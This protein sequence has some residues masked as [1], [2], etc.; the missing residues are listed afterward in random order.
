MHLEFEALRRALP[1]TV[2]PLRRCS[3]SALV[4]QAGDFV[5][6]MPLA[7]PARGQC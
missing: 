7:D 5:E 3:E 4:P 1:Y 2:S 6:L